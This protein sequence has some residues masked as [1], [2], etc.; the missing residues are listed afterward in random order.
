MADHLSGKTWGSWGIS[1]LIV[2]V[3]AFLVISPVAAQAAGPGAS[4][5]NQAASMVPAAAQAV[6]AAAL[7][8]A[9][10]VGS[11]VAVP[12]SVMPAPAVP[13]EGSP[14]SPPP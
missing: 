1:A 10:S 2:V 12:T 7:K 11:N 13:L 5:A 6:V 8:Q 9:S 4:A 14:A 3:L